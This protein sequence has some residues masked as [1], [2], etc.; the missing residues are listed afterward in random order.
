VEEEVRRRVW[1]WKGE[2]E[3]GESPT[4]QTEAIT[5]ASL[6]PQRH[7]HNKDNA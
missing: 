2:G 5:P 4:T 3:G 7:T 6:P 1:V